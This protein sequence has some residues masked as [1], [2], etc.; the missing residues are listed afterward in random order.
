MFRIVPFTLQ[1]FITPYYVQNPGPSSVKST[2]MNTRI[3]AIPKL[4][5]EILI[6]IVIDK[7]GHAD[8]YASKLL[9]NTEK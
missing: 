9:S 6:Y 7:K 4:N 1:I 8:V 3:F 2:K 5:A